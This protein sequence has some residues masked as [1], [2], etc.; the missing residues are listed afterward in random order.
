MKVYIGPY[1]HWFAPYRWAKQFLRWRYGV[2]KARVNL[3][4]YDK[5]NTLARKKFK[6]LR[7]IEEWFDVRYKRKVR[8]RVDYYDTWG[9]D[10]TLKPIILP[11]LKQLQAT[12]HGSA[13]VDD[14]DVPE[15][16]KSTSAEPLTDEQKNMGYTDNNVHKRW[17]WVMNEM[18]WAFEQIDND[19]AESQFHTDANPAKPRDE[20][21]ISFEEGMRRGKF[22]A[23]GYTAWQNRKTR[24]LTLFGKYFEGLWD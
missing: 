3:A 23:E 15:E 7:A 13:M 22:D 20:P 19:D 4:E 21:G 11:L 18:I 6:W 8:V 12:K 10:S 17:D 14:D 5:V 1:H 9:V 2:N 16:L 24:G